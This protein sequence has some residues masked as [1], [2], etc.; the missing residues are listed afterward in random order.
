MGARDAGT[1]FTCFPSTKV[2]I[3]TRA[4]AEAAVGARDAGGTQFTCFTSTK[5]QILAQK[6]EE[7][8]LEEEQDLTLLALPVHKYKY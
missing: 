4:A 3:L 8:A 7:Q 1:Q 6:L 5:V 2:Q